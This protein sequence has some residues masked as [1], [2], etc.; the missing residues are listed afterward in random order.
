MSAPRASAPAERASGSA[1][2]YAEVLAAAVLW[3]SSGIFAVALFRRGASPGAV[4]LLRPVVGMAFL[5]AAA[6][7]LRRDAF[8]RPSRAALLWTVG[9][10]GLATAVF[11]VAYQMALAT[12]GVP[13]TVALLYLAP[14]L[15]VASAGPLLGEWPG[16]S[17]VGLA[18]LSV[19]GVWL[20]VAGARG[21]EVSVTPAGV[22]WGLLAAVS[23]AGYT[24]FGRMASPRFGAVPTVL[25]STLGACVFLAAALPLSGI[26]LAFPNDPVA[27]AVLAAFGLLTIAAATFLFYDGLG[28]IEASRA[29]ITT[30]AEPVVAA[31]LATLLLDQGLTVR[32]WLGLALVVAGVAGAYASRKGGAETPV[33]PGT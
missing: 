21:V 16:R 29:A 30:T 28:R 8:R 27:W 6:L 9:I 15:V 31:V 11:Q 4:A 5:V 24:L 7:V 10:G 32:G 22:A 18:A 3:G 25:G 14:A 19:V 23:Y 26:G 20:T 1:A 2:G 13:T 12:T 33:G 17:R